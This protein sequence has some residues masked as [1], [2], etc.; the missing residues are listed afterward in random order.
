MNLKFIPLEHSIYINVESIGNLQSAWN[1][2]GTGPFFP[3][4]H[5]LS[6]I[7]NLLSLITYSYS[8]IP[9]IIFFILSIGPMPISLIPHTYSHLPYHINHIPCPIFL[10]LY[11]YIEVLIS[12]RI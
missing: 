8:H 1:S 5:P 9:N 12:N 3:I 2:S 11:I 6:Q 4:L 10:I 7:Y